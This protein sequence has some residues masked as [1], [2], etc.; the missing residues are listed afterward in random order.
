[1]D[2]IYLEMK[3][4]PKR[5]ILNCREDKKANENKTWANIFDKSTPV[6]VCIIWNESCLKSALWFRLLHVNR[7]LIY[8]P[9]L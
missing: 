2:H 9:L 8:E 1:M 4:N 7:Y 5:N 6:A 3:R